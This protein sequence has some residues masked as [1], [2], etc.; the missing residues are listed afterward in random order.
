M[1]RQSPNI[2]I[3]E[4]SGDNYASLEAAQRAAIEGISLHMEQTIR[5]LLAAG[6]LIDL[7]GNIIPNPKR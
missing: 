5:D 2:T 3:E 4:S 7:N 6:R 1:A